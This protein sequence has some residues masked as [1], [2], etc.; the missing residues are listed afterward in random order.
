MTHN[1]HLGGH[2]DLLTRSLTST[3]VDASIVLVDAGQDQLGH[4]LTKSETGTGL[5]TSDLVA[6]LVPG[7][8]GRGAARGRAREDQVAGDTCGHV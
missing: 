5:A 7:C 4:A 2:Y 1:V 6:I 8:G 3:L